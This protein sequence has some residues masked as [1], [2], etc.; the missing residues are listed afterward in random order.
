[1]KPSSPTTTSMKT[2]AQIPGI[3]GARRAALAGLMLL[4]LVLSS[5]RASTAAVWLRL[6]G[7]GPVTT[8]PGAVSQIEVLAF[9][10]EVAKEIDPATG[11]AT[12]KRTHAP[13]RVVIPHSRTLPQLMNVL[14]A[15]ETIA[16]GEL[17]FWE[18]TAPGAIET[19]V[20]E[21]RLAGLKIESVRP[22][23]PNTRDAEARG[24]GAA[25]EVAFTYQK[26]EWFWLA[27]NILAADEPASPP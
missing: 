9:N 20:M 4:G 26:I 1:M 22:W 21:Y 17:L 25:V 24:M 27:G 19:K 8:Q 6:D 5:Q 7:I 13:L 18:A 3:Q 23:M 2:F 12:G 15:N 14:V 16:K 11:Q 10:H